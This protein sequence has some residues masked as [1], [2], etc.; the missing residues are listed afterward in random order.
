[1]ICPFSDR[2]AGANSVDQDRFRIITAIF[3]GV[4]IFRNFMVQST[5]SDMFLRWCIL[6][7]CI[8][9]TELCIYM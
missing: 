8:C 1:M 2:Q 9:I 4:Q 7:L 3:W 5:L 6:D